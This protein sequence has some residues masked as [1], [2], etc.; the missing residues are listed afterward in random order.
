MVNSYDPETNRI[1]LSTKFPET[2]PWKDA[3]EK[4]AVGNI[5][6]GKVVRFADFGAFVE[7]A[8]GVDA[9]V[10][11]SHLSRKF[12]KHP[13]EVLTIGQEVEAKVIDFNEEAKRISLSM[14]ELEP[15]APVEAEEE[16]AETTEE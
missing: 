13:S 14:R 9:L 15:E 11:I 6:T 7:L 16:V 2:N 3:A 10:H 1:S 4:F 8:K 5:V 12:V